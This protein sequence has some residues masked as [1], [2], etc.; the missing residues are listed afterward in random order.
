[1]IGPRIPT[2]IGCTHTGGG[3]DGDKLR[4]CSGLPWDHQLPHTDGFAT[5]DQHGCHTICCRCREC[6]AHKATSRRRRVM[7][8]TDLSFEHGGKH[9]T[10]RT[11]RYDGLVSR[12]GGF[13]VRFRASNGAE[14]V[15]DRESAA[16]IIRAARG[17][18][19]SRMTWSFGIR[20]ETARRPEPVSPPGGWTSRVHRRVES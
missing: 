8:L 17:T 9:V 1:M 20:P 3:W 11:V 10:L 19:P 12:E 5:W 4:A 18:S 16:V 15:I 14:V 13:D 6:R 2:A 7:P